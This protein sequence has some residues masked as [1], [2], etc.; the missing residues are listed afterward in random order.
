MHLQATIIPDF[1][2]HLK[3]SMQSRPLWCDVNADTATVAS[4][5]YRN[6][7]HCITVYGLQGFKLLS[8]T[9]I[10]VDA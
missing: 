10:T 7:R 6:S 9:E 2:I 8:L 4:A 1:T 5:P 3:R